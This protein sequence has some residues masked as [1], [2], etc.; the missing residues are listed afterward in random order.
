M[1]PNSRS[2]I[3]HVGLHKTA[4][5]SIQKTL[6][7]NRNV[8]KKLG[9]HYGYFTNHQ[10]DLQ[11][12]HSLP[13]RICFSEDYQS[14]SYFYDKAIAPRAERDR[15]IAQLN[16]NLEHDEKIVFSGE[17]ISILS[18]Q[19]LFTLKAF[20]EA[21]NMN[22]NVIC[23]VR[24]PYQV[25]CSGGQEWAKT[26]HFYRVKHKASMP[27]VH[28]IKSVFPDTSFHSFAT[29]CEHV[30]G[31]I[32]YFL[33]L[34][35]IR[36]TEDITMHTANKGLS[37]QAVRLLAGI[38]EMVPLKD[39]N[40]KNQ[41]RKLHDTSELWGIPGGKYRLLKS[42]F[43]PLKP[44]LHA[45]NEELKTTLGAAYCDDAFPVHDK[46]LSWGA[47]SFEYYRKKLK[48]VPPVVGVLSYYYFAALQVVGPEK[49]SQIRHE[50]STDAHEAMRFQT[51]DRMSELHRRW[52]KN[53]PAKAERLA[54]AF[55]T[56]L[57]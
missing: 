18:E 57:T 4:T 42:E 23:F 5:S 31:P 8:I 17:G 1:R 30:D 12:N 15:F 6:S 32:G 56:R 21:R 40:P 55:S 49:M 41:L 16:E 28:K 13:F 36:Q 35:G 11:A 37:D 54:K 53:N 10:G 27:L 44:S 2:V 26:G 20:F 29:A 3:L 34:V 43:T 48:S 7:S 50:L 51:L 47:K 52:N 9:L 46:P 39:G 45:E 25:T 22:L 24:S 19:E 14:H 33:E 38:N